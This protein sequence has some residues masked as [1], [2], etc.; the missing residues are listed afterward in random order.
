VVMV[1]WWVI[2]PPTL[3]HPALKIAEDFWHD[4]C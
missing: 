2:A 1:G 3:P 4:S